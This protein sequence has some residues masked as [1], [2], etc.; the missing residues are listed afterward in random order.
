VLDDRRFALQRARALADRG[1]GNAAIRF[2][3]ER[4]GLEPVLVEEALAALD[5]ERERA[6]RIIA[7]HGSGLKTARL[8]ASRGFDHE[9][10]ERAA[11]AAVAP[12]Q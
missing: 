12:E 11:E 3:L 8:L 6:E 2:D 5:P 9:V 1:K 4:Q 7:R 10:A